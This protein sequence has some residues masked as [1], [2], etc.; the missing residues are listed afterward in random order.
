M[1]LRSST[2]TD[3]AAI[4]IYPL[5]YPAPLATSSSWLCSYRRLTFATAAHVSQLHLDCERA[6][7]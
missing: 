2:R 1:N 4:G 5:A 7:I 3:T 6:R